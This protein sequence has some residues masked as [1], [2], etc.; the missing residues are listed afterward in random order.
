MP[1]TRQCGQ[2]INKINKLLENDY[3]LDVNLANKYIREAEEIL[4]QKKIHT[5]DSQNV[6]WAKKQLILLLERD[7][8]E[9]D[10]NY[11]TFEKEVEN[12]IQSLPNNDNENDRLNTFTK[13]QQNAM[14]FCANNKFDENKKHALEKSCSKLESLINNY[15]DFSNLMH[16]LGVLENT[17]HLLE[18]KEREKIYQ[19]YDNMMQIRKMD[20]EYKRKLAEAFDM[21]RAYPRVIEEQRARPKPKSYIRALQKKSQAQYM[22]AVFYYMSKDK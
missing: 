18:A 22:P 15:P 13:L 6:K 11:K 4:K 2:L 5:Y 20:P 16:H 7:A 1:T 21:S 8:K 3:I 9:T 10:Q 19:R 14:F 12:A 17:P